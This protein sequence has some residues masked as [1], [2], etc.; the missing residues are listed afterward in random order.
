MT[1]P[2]AIPSTTPWHARPAPE[3]LAALGTSAEG[4][5]YAEAEARLARD[6][7]NR[8]PEPPRRSVL[9]RFLAQFRN[10]LLHAAR[11]RGDHRVP[12]PRRRHRRDPRRGRG[13][14]PHRVC[15]GGQGRA[16]DGRDPY[17]ARA[18]HRCRAG[19][20]APDG[21]GGRDVA[22]RHRA[23]RGRRPGARRPAADRAHGLSIEEAI[24]TGESVPRRSTSPRWLRRPRSAIAR[25]WRGAARCRDRPGNG[26]GGRDGR[27]DRDRPDQRAVVG[28]DAADHA[29]RAADGHLRPRPDRPHPRPR[30]SPPRLWHARRA[31]ALH[32]HVHA[33]RGALR[34]G[35]P[36]GAAGRAHDHPGDRRSGEWRSAT[37]SCAACRRSRRWARCR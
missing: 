4:L 21:G 23:P 29:A 25:P 22:G 2:P 26:R 36:R 3:C 34:R 12:R 17:D 33:G 18:A 28:V 27:R 13:E 20:R 10:V 37:R 11:V 35:D 32:R 8:L 30:R 9:A 19:R 7:P 6:G 16:G 14:R 5:A 31:S 15:A 24:L 1:T